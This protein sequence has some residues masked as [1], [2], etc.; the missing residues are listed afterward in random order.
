MP[1]QA[2]EKFRFSGCLDAKILE[3]SRAER[4]KDSHTDYEIGGVAP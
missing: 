1:L 3:K 4:D 2:R